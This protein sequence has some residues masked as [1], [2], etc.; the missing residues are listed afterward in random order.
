LP[1]FAE[2]RD[3]P[4]DKRIHPEGDV[5][6]HTLACCRI[7]EDFSFDPALRAA[8][9]FHDIGKSEC[10]RKTSGGTSFR[11]HEEAG[12][13]R[14]CKI[15]NQWAWPKD[16]VKDVTRL[17]EWH[18]LLS[19]EC[20][21]EV[22]RRLI[23]SRGESWVDRLFLL[24]KADLLAGSGDLWTWHKNRRIAVEIV[25]RL[26]GVTPPLDGRD[27]MNILGVDEGPLIG[28]ALSAIAAEMEQRGPM[29]AE[30]AADFLRGWF[31]KRERS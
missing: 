13:D 3:I 9:L 24:S 19:R 1:F 26:S 21:H 16:L 22:W 14:T 25:L 6:A 7:M 20:D 28:K 8:A 5:Y 29:D 30:K 12:A 11:G 17:V 27:V 31:S 4:Q 15:L 18:G 23:A 10:A 2:L